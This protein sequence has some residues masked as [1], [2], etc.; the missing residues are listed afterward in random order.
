MWKVVIG[1]S[2]LARERW[3]SGRIYKHKRS[4]QRRAKRISAAH[5]L[6]VSTIF[7]L[8]VYENGVQRLE[9]KV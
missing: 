4:A 1:G 5:D 8:R 2:R 7:V 3:K 6:E 9:G